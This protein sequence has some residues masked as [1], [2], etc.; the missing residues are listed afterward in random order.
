MHDENGS[1]EE[2][3][4]LLPEELLKQQLGKVILGGAWTSSTSHGAFIKTVYPSIRDSK[5][6]ERIHSILLA[7]AANPPLRME[8]ADLTKLAE[9]FGLSGRALYI[10]ASL[11]LKGTKE[12]MLK[13]IETMGDPVTFEDYSYL[14]WV[15]R[16]LKEFPI[17][18]I[19]KVERFLAQQL[20]ALPAAW[21]EFVWNPQNMSHPDRQRFFTFAAAQ[22]ALKAVNPVVAVT[23]AFKFSAQ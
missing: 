5:L 3:W 1:I 22:D 17:Q 23:Y 12:A 15:N 18:K 6:K 21:T 20:D 4:K 7:S 9:L 11:K 8:S 2:K 16:S 10:C 19:Q 13:V 14:L